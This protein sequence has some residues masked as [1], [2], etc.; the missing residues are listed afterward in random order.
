MHHMSS[1]PSGDMSFDPM[2]MMLFTVLTILYIAAAAITHRRFRKWPVYRTFCWAAGIWSAALT[3]DGP[4]VAYAHESFTI[5]MAGHLLL[6][7]LA[8]LF[9]VMASPVTLMLRSLPI[10]L[11]RRFVRV[12]HMRYFHLVMHPVVAALLNIGGLWA[13]YTTGLYEAMHNSDMVYDVVHIHLFLAGY[14]FTSS[15]IYLD[16]VSRRFS[17]KYRAIVLILAIAGHSILS[18]WLYGSP[19]I[20]VPVEQAEAAAILMYYGGDVIELLLI[21]LFCFHWY[22]YRISSRSI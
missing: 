19:P 14:L 21:V 6:G 17:F 20:G 1:G 11:A 13:L 12:R 9:I 2:L 22:K 10:S 8:P 3:V 18:K 4:L 7:M 5:H 16:P 15:I